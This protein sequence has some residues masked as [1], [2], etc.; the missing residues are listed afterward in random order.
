MKKEILEK[1]NGGGW[2][3][4]SI[5]PFVFARVIK[6]IILGLLLSITFWLFWQGHFSLG[7]FAVGSIGG[8]LVFRIWSFL[9]TQLLKSDH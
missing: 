8:F 4:E 2:G 7:A 3:L 5:F 9:K 1:L 6:I